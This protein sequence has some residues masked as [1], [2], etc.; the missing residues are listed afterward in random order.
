M[1][2][3]STSRAQLRTEGLTQPPMGPGPRRP[4]THQPHEAPHIHRSEAL[5]PVTSQP[6]RKSPGPKWHYN[7]PS[8]S[9][10]PQVPGARC[11]FRVRPRADRARQQVT[12]ARRYKDHTEGSEKHRF[13]HVACYRSGGT[14]P[15]SWNLPDGAST[16]RRSERTS[17]TDASPDDARDRT[18]TNTFCP[19]TPSFAT[20]FSMP[21]L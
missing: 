12:G 10:K 9:T 1:C 19:I 20:S 6:R 14:F 8:R 5:T 2:P 3:Y 13:H 4:S 21:R 18:P 16:H 11:Q 7:S 15:I 17:A